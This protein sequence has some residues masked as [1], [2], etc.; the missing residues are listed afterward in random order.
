MTFIVSESGQEGQEGSHAE[1]SAGSENR[2]PAKYK[3]NSLES[4]EDHLGNSS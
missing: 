2:R 4:T 3:Q 1:M